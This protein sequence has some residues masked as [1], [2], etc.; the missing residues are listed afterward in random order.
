MNLTVSLKANQTIF[1]VMKKIILFAC[2]FLLWASDNS[3]GQRRYSPRYNYHTVGIHLGGFNYLGDLNPRTNPMSMNLGMT[4]FGF[5]TD[6]TFKVAQNIR[7]RSMLSVGQVRGDDASS[8]DPND[9]KAIFRYARNLHFRNTLVEVAQ[10]IVYDLVPGKGRF[11][12]R[13]STVPYIFTGTAVFMSNPKARVPEADGNQWVALRPLETEGKKYSAVSIAIPVGVGVRFK[14]GDRLD[15]AVE[16]CLRFTLTD[17]IDDVSG[18]YADPTTLSSDLAKKMSNRTTETTSRF[19]NKERDMTRVT[20]LLG[21]PLTDNG[22][23]RLGGMGMAGDIRG[24]P[25]KDA[26]LSFTVQANYVIGIKSYRP[27]PKGK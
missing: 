9:D 6:I 23:Q 20:S 13:A 17:Y 12:R 27:R 3:F 26:Y 8:A 24:L 4:S 19:N 22:V 15:I 7:F 14:L 11:Y 18:K 16:G 1:N 2:L 25:D 10:H 5:G 21:T